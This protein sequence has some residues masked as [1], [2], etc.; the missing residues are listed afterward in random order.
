MLPSAVASAYLS[1]PAHYM[2]KNS[3]AE[4]FFITP[5]GKFYNHSNTYYDFIIYLFQSNAECE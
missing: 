2:H 1:Y 5:Q 4:P 3:I